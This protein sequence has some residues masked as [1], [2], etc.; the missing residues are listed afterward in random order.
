MFIEEKQFV[1]LQMPHNYHTSSSEIVQLTCCPQVE[2]GLEIQTGPVHHV[3]SM[4]LARIYPIAV[5]PIGKKIAIFFPRAY[6]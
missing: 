4:T 1:H 2:Q 5:V 6:F 3:L